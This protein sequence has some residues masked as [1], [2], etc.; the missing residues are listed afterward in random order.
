VPKAEKQKAALQL[1]RRA[2]GGN[3]NLLK[4]GWKGWRAMN[5]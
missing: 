3:L 5:G 4:L 1:I 2:A